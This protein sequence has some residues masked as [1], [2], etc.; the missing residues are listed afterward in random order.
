MWWLKK[1]RKREHDFA[2]LEQDTDERVRRSH[3]LVSGADQA[4][5]R[6][7]LVAKRSTQ[8]SEANNIAGI[9]ARSLGLTNGHYNGKRE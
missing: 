9:L 8:L 6:S 2:Q 5:E 1:M 3:E 7:A 4:S